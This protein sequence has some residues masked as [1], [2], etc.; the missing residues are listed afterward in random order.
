MNQKLSDPK[1]QDK[2]IY[3]YSHTHAH[4][5]TNAAFLICAWFLLY[6]NKTPEEAFRPFK[7]YI[8]PFPPWV[9]KT[10]LDRLPF[11]NTPRLIARC[12][13]FSLHI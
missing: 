7:S 10:S 5:R 13:S 11:F 8:A 6:Q 3:H 2:I 9:S 4:K 12:Y 1:L